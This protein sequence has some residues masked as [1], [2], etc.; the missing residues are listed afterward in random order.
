MGALLP[1]TTGPLARG[2]CLF[3]LAPFSFRSI[4][5]FLLASFLGRMP[6]AT[7]CGLALGFRMPATVS[8]VGR[9]VVAA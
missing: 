4:M 9:C 3:L 2:S 6:L 7:E 5:A 8:T 1:F